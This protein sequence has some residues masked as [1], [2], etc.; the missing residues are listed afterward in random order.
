[1]VRLNAH[2]ANSKKVSGASDAA[3][4]VRTE[5]FRRQHREILEVI[6]E[7]TTKLD[8]ASIEQD[9]ASVRGLLNVLVGKLTVHLAMEDDALYPRMLHHRNPQIREL[10]TSFIAELGGI[11]EAFRQYIARWSTAQLILANPAAFIQETNQ[12]FEALKRR[13]AREDNELYP[14]LDGKD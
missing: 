6:D 13:I 5:A 10:A 14:K 4:T 2:R 11:A 8:A 9:A 12:V 3:K 7:L 1:V